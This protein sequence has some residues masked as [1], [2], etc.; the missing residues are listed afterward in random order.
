MTI[1]TICSTAVAIVQKKEGMC[2]SILQSHNRFFIITSAIGYLVQV[3]QTGQYKSTGPRVI[4][5]KLNESQR[6][7][8][9]TD[10]PI[11]IKFQ[12]GVIA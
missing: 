4:V 5:L 6:G 1:T 9:T 10:K 3:I 8:F 11:S 12:D 2:S 7:C